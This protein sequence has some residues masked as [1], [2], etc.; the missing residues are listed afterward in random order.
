VRERRAEGRAHL[1]QREYAAAHSCF[2]L[3]AVADPMGRQAFMGLL[4]VRTATLQHPCFL[5][6][7]SQSM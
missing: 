7:S 2:E 5:L 3:A 1:G 4:E 6:I